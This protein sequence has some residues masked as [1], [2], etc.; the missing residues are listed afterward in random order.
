[1]NEIETRILEV[2]VPAVVAQLEELGAK[3]LFSGTLTDHVF[4]KDKYKG[5]FRIREQG[6]AVCTTLK[7]KIGA[8]TSIT[9]V[10]DEREHAVPSVQAGEEEAKKLG[11]KHIKTIQK[12][13]TEYSIDKTHF[14]LDTHPGIP[15][16]L[17]IESPT[18]EEVIAWVEK[19]GFSQTD[20]RKWGWKK[21]SEHYEKQ[22]ESS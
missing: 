22:R 10:R 1:V 13:R 15:T 19:L 16:Y 11:F 14:A 18:E 20:M 17:E 9:K 21:V 4:R 12:E 6:N 3:K 8:S 2:D 7:T 5:F